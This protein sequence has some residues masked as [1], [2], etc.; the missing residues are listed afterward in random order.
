MACNKKQCVEEW[1][2]RLYGKERPAFDEDEESLEVLFQ[3]RCRFLLMEDRMKRHIELLG[4]AEK[5]FQTQGWLFKSSPK[6]SDKLTE[7][8]RR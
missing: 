6:E 1:L 5:H 3:M 2:E 7:T 4:L 8:H